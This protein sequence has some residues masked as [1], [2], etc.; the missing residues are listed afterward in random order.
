MFKLPAQLI[1]NHV[2]DL[3]LE[4]TKL[5]GSGESVVLD[6]SDVQKAD[7]AG[8]QLL[9]AVQKNLNDIGNNIAW[10]GQSSALR[11]TAKII[12]VDDFLQL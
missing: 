12:G 9:C 11:D 4:L 7:T 1:I 2:E 10:Q 6:I 3:Y 8:L 5:L